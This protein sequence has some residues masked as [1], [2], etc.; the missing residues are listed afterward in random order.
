VSKSIVRFS[1]DVSLVDQLPLSKRNRE[2]KRLLAAVG[3]VLV[4]IL[5]M[6]PI[7]SAQSQF[8]TLSGTVN[9]PSGAAVAG[10]KVAVK[11]QRRASHARPRPMVMA[12]SP[13]LRSRGFV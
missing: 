13:L 8:A 11:V 3:V 12:S 5:L 2:M 10:A 9:D 6:Q 4:A 7:A 1:I